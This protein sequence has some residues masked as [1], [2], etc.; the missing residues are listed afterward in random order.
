[1]YVCK[2]LT[3]HLEAHMG[4]LECWHMHF[5]QCNLMKHQNRCGLDSLTITILVPSTAIG[6]NLQKPVE[7]TICRSGPN[8]VLYK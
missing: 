5:L 8:Q 1:M 7:G 6:I 3:V 4:S 2:I